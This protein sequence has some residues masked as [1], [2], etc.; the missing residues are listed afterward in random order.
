MLCINEIYE[1]QN[2][3]KVYESM[4][5]I[6]K[7]HC[8]NLTYNDFF[9]NYMLRNRPLI[10]FGISDNWE[11]SSDWVKYDD[12]KR[13]NGKIDFD[14]L[15]EKILKESIVPVINCKNQAKLE[16]NFD[17]FLSYWENMTDSVD[18]PESKDLYYLKDWHLRNKMPNYKFYEVPKYFGSD[19]LNEYLLQTGSD[20]YRFVYMGP[21]KTW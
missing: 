2:V 4:C 9:R 3:N 18:I 11:C 12:E 8:D 14:N 21:N 20:D 16:M 7:F 10:I 1:S 19:W 15:K 5:K 17:N 6:D 13:L